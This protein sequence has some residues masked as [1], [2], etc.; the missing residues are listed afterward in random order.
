MPNQRYAAIDQGT[1]GT[2]V[3]VF[4]EDGT[5]HSPAAIAHKQITPDSGWVEHDPMEILGNIR[6]CLSDCNV[7]DAIG[8][9]HQGESIVAWDAQSGLPLYNAIVWQDQR[10]ESVIRQLKEDG[11]E[12]MVREKTGLPLDTYFSASKMGWIMRNVP[13]A[14]KLARNGRL[15]LGTM[16]AFFLFHLCGTHATDYNSA[17]RTSLFNIR[18]LQWDDA[19]CRLFGVPIEALPA[20]KDNIG[21][22]GDVTL[23]GKTVPLTACIVDQFAG[24]YGHGC[25]SPGQMKITF[26]T[27]AFLQ[28]ITGN[29]VP[30]AANSG[31]LPTLCWK[32]PGEEPVYGLDGGVYN[33]ASAI[34]W[35]RKIGLFTDIEDFSDFP[36]QPAIA[37]G[38]AFVPALSGLG[39]PYWDR[40]AAGLWAGLS[41]ETER[42]DMLQS[43]LEGIAVRSAEV[44]NAM[45]KVQP[46]GDS[47]TV[48]GG[49]SSNRYFKQ[50]LSD[51]IQK[52]IV[53]PVNR[54]M[55]AQG[56]ALLAQ[57][58][59]GNHDAFKINGNH[60]VI[61]PQR[62]DLQPFYT[63]YLDIISRSR[64]LR[65]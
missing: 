19:L 17:S 64:N 7:V 57:K 52:H 50:F 59:L 42:K 9:A 27:G 26:G 41:L 45:D 40:S 21:Y 60:E 63:R 3:I 48:D 5:H 14:K 12:A 30:D 38:L 47:I 31:L 33:A 1:T 36:N 61:T 44:I 2:R 10:T 43:I 65:A 11:A 58:G 62:N 29:A 28:S 54:E 23:A 56:V 15:R 22:F 35:A 32:L 34:N 25:R 4:S 53:S 20:V 16:D 51:L 24:T 18:T 37:R 6:L 13:D 55:T 49:L 39:C 46:I 8:L